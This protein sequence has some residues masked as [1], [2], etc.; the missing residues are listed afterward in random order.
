[1]ATIGV[2]Q[3]NVTYIIYKGKIIA[4]FSRDFNTSTTNDNQNNN[5]TNNNQNNNIINNNQSSTNN[6]NSVSGNIENNTQT[7]TSKYNPKKVVEDYVKTVSSYTNSQEILDNIDFRGTLAWIDAK[8]KYSDFIKIYDNISNDRI[9]DAEVEE[10][11][12]WSYG[13]VK[14]EIVKYEDIRELGE[15]LYIVKAEL[16]R[17]GSPSFSSYY[18]V[19]KDKIIV[20]TTYTITNDYLSQYF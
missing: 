19:Y 18:V 11:K 12:S 5:I 13:S 20:P 8:G 17:D 14:K 1:M 9:K 15:G 10:S 16:K 6:K 3:G 4:P 2:G 7:N